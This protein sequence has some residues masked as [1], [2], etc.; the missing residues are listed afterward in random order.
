MPRKRKS[1]ETESRLSDT[2][3]SADLSPIKPQTP[4]DACSSSQSSPGHE[5]RSEQDNDVN[6]LLDESSQEKRLKIDLSGAESEDDPLPQL[7][8]PLVHKMTQEKKVEPLLLRLHNES[9]VHFGITADRPP[10]DRVYEVT[11]IEAT[12]LGLVQSKPP[13][14][15]S[16]CVEPA[17]KPQMHV[18]NITDSPA[19]SQGQTK[20]SIV[21]SPGASSFLENVTVPNEV[22]SNSL[23]QDSVYSDIG[24]VRHQPE[25]N[26]GREAVNLKLEPGKGGVSVA[27]HTVHITVTQ[28]KENADRMQGTKSLSKKKE[29][30][31]TQPL[32]TILNSSLLS[33]SDKSRNIKGMNCY[34]VFLHL[35]PV[36]GFQLSKYSP[37]RVL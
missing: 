4:P 32:E 35:F 19:Y 7:P 24:S 15:D 21:P 16:D 28:G 6:S 18:P 31:G 34:L 2:S 25:W 5:I 26:L 8:L 33:E 3:S 20:H 27:K 23:P 13:K 29:A 36:L 12:R 9:R 30:E 10:E 37:F 1:Q 22:S 11:H 17:R 14:R